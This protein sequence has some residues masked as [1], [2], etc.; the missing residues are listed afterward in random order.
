MS[1]SM[2]L[3]G[4]LPLFTLHA[5]H[6][7]GITTGVVLGRAEDS[8]GA[9]VPNVTVTATRAATGVKL[10]TTTDQKGE[11][12]FR[13]VPAG[14]YTVTVEGA[15][16]AANKVENVNVAAG[17]DTNLEAIKMGLGSAATNVE[18]SSAVTPLLQTT[19][20]Q[21]STTFD[22]LQTQD[23]PLNGSLDNIALFT[24]GVAIGHDAAFSNSNG[25][26]LSIN[27]QRSRSNNFEIDGQGNND[28]SVGGPQIFFA[29]QDALQSVEVITSNF[30]A[31]YGRNMG[32]VV[33]Y[34]SKA[35]TNQ[36][37]GSG[38][39]FF[40]SDFFMA[41]DQAEKLASASLPHY[42]D[43]RYGGT[44]GGPVLKDKA[45]FFGGTNW[46]QT[47][48]GF[49]PLI[50]TNATPT[51]DG[52]RQL[53]AAFPQSNAVN[54]LSLQGPYAVLPQVHPVGAT[55][56]RSVTGPNGTM[57]NI[58]FSQISTSVAPSYSDQEDLGRLDW[59]PT[60][61]DHLFA[62][63]IYQNTNSVGNQQANGYYYNIPNVTH[64][65][66][67]DWAHTFSPNWV[68]QVHYG[69]QQSKLFFQGGVQPNCTGQTLSACTSSVTITGT[70]G[71][72]YNTNLPQGRVVKVNQVQDNAN[73]THG[74]HSIS[75]GGDFTYQNSPNTFLP[76]Y[77]GGYVFQGFSNFLQQAGN[78][79]L[80]DGSA[81]IPFT[82]PDFGL[83]VQDDWKVL[84]SLTLNLGF[85]YEFF[86]QAVNTLHNESVAQQTGPN[87]FW[88][89]TLPLSATTY[90][91]TD[92][93]YKN[94]QPRIGFAFN[95]ASLPK[96]VVRG[97]YGIQYDP[98]FYN[99]F[100]N[101]AT[102]APVVNLGNIACNGTC[103]PGGG[104]SGAN[105]RALNLGSIPRGVN[106]AV[107]NFTNNPT[108]FVNPRAQTYS[109][110]LQYQLQGAVIGVS[111]VG[112][113]VS[114][115]FLSV[116]A[117]PF[118]QPV[119]QNFPN[120]VAPG[121][122]CQDPNAIGYGRLSCANANVRTRNNNAFSL[123]NSLQ[124]QVQTRNYHGATV[125]ASYT[126]SRVIDNGD[127]VYGATSPSGTVSSPSFAQNPLQT[128]SPE[129][130][131][132]NYSYPN[133]AS[134]GLNYEVPFYKNKSGLL[135]RVLGGYEVTSAW[136]FNNGEP[137]TPQQSYAPYFSDPNAK[138]NS[139]LNVS[140]YCDAPFNA[141]IVFADTCRPVL[142][143]AAAPLSS[144][145]VYVTDPNQT[146]TSAGTGYYQYQPGT[147]GKLTTQT[148]ANQVHWLYNN[149]AYANLVGNP[150][151]GTPRNTVRGQSYN[152]LDAAVVK[153]TNIR[154][155]VA[156][157]L[158]FNAFNVLNR[159]FY[160]TPD[161]SIEDASYGTFLNNR[162]NYRGTLQNS[163]PASRFVQLGGKVVF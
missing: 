64:S 132:S 62:R 65:I 78:L 87:P 4:A 79:T 72:G 3:A 131:V 150:F 119:A 31:E 80:A 104:V 33:N 29:N 136:A 42:V 25:N 26:D 113:H 126:Y 10:A 58:P 18:V 120:V 36:F 49:S 112:N 90:P 125:N 66:G 75:F 12:S 51:Q 142:S 158:Y 77:N 40:T 17:Q 86:S 56:V 117:N 28:N 138:A 111:Y 41:R 35:G 91:L 93:N 30:N 16:F 153:T 105:V 163:V 141:A 7:Q 148:T 45:W 108:T 128:D 24:P 76:S 20:S 19:E 130:G 154:E 114:R 109:L 100:L 32:G 157:K 8:S 115:Q 156:V 83:Y 81:L 6:G 116:D 69:F 39:E 133:L 137:W 110:G 63:Y 54:A 106:P 124:A 68:N 2:L 46:E 14:V 143:N 1:A 92:S 71:F 88:A 34:V 161:T 107:R 101:S 53:Q 118:L 43:N 50:V 99:I 13:N 59:Q 122:L 159:A 23:L 61:K 95:P 84:P 134:I 57:L 151:P 82:E 27:G 73:W 67:A 98:A 129:R 127:E 85:R 103:I 5:A 162:G 21:V 155:G 47:H 160:G 146:F 94:L 74:K 149:R 140:S 102:A 145:G 96:L 44:F 147:G 144:V 11:F 70:A 60:S 152:N 52:I 97:A 15:G 135:G 89:T 139:G 48:E 123:Y 38:Y 9:V 37:H 55:T 121:S 22:A